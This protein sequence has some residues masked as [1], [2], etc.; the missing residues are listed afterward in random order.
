[1]ILT[2][3]GSLG[4]FKFVGHLQKRQAWSGHFV[5]NAKLLKESVCSKNQWETGNLG[6]WQ[7]NLVT[8]RLCLWCRKICVGRPF[9]LRKIKILVDFSRKIFDKKLSL[10]ARKPGA[11]PKTSSNLRFASWQKVGSLWA[12]Q[13]SM[14]DSKPAAALALKRTGSRNSPSCLRL[15]NRSK[16]SASSSG[17]SEPPFCLRPRKRSFKML[18]SQPDSFDI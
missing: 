6:Y 5:W 4:F 12:L 8:T 1:M 3:G 2:I 7:G 10:T 15:R 16:S 18:G 11:S 9:W 13:K 17:L 14:I